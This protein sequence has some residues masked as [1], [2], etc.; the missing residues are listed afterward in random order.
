[1][2]SG[3]VLDEK[4]G[5]AK[6]SGLRADLSQEDRAVEQWFEDDEWEQQRVNGLAKKREGKWTRVG[7]SGSVAPETK[8]GEG[9]K[10]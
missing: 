2:G 5:G 4:T 3:E 9:I 1:M 10:L 8:N 6:K 7:G